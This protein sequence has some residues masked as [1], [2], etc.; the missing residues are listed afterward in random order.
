[1]D[2]NQDL[3]DFIRATDHYPELLI[4]LV[5]D[6]NY[7]S[8]DD[9]NIFLTQE[10]KIVSSDKGSSGDDVGNYSYGEIPDGDKQ[11]RRV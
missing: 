5:Q 8:D 1:M 11:I 10:E 7:E 3:C 6:V 4:D 9:P 2:I